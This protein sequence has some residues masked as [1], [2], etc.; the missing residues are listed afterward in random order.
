MSVADTDQSPC[1]S[2][3]RQLFFTIVMDSTKMPISLP[4]ALKNSGCAHSSV[5][6]HNMA[7]IDSGVCSVSLSR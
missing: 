4:S 3:A 1:F 6:G 2:L 7:A 5:G